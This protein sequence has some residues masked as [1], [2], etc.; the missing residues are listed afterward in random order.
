MVVSLEK[1]YIICIIASY[2]YVHATWKKR[3]KICIR[4]NYAGVAV[5]GRSC[6]KPVRCSKWRIAAIVAKKS[7]KIHNETISR[8]VP[9]RKLFI[10]YV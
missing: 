3:A 4:G 7:V 10:V 8:N 5:H 6:E 9:I 1:W 2:T